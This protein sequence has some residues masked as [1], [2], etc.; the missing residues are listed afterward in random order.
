MRLGEDCFEMI[1]KKLIIM[2]DVLMM[3][4]FIILQNAELHTLQLY[5]D[6]IN[7]YALQS[8]YQ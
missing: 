7:S 1:M 4:R 5:Y 8:D 6:L 2:L 3:V